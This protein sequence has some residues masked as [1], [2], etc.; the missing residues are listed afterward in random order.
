MATPSD[1]I[2]QRNDGKF[3]VIYCHYDGYVDWNGIRILKYYNT[4]LNAEAL[5]EPGDMK[6]LGPRPDY[7]AGHT[8]E[9]PVEGHC[10]YFGREDKRTGKE[11]KLYPTLDEALEAAHC[12]FTYLWLSD[13]ESWYVACEREDDAF[14]K[15]EDFKSLSDAIFDRLGDFYCKPEFRDL[16]DYDEVGHREDGY[17]MIPAHRMP[18]YV[19][20]AFDPTTVPYNGGWA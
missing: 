1:I 19:E 3:A 20:P 15:F 4:Q 11:Y 14:L 10:V 17:G 9:E 13:H 5:V 2:V 16:P 18:G 8:Y 12:R 7:V 6:G